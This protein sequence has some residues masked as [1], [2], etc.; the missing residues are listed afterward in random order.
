VEGKSIVLEE[1]SSEGRND[2]RFSDLV[3]ELVR[4]KVNII[5]TGGTPA[6]LAAKQATATIP[7]VIAG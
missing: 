3:S 4:L 5:V 2:E 6:T 7:I 1:R